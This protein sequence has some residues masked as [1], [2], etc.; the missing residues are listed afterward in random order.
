MPIIIHGS[1]AITGVKQTGI[2][3]CPSCNTK[4]DYKWKHVR[5]WGHLYFIPIAPGQVLGEYVE[6]QRCMN[7]YKPGV[8]DYDPEAAQ[9][10]FEATYQSGMK[11]VMVRMMASDGSIDP[12][13]VQVVRGIFGRL[14]G[15][16][17]SDD[18]LNAEIEAARRDPQEIGAA[19]KELAGTLNEKGKAA[20]V[21]AAYL[22]AS[23]D[24]RFERAE[25]ELLNQV[26]GGLGMSL[27]Q[28]Q[29]AIRELNAPAES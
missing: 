2:F 1:R 7:T 9:K 4:V 21:K 6:C 5:K 19:L 22:V 20:V 11:R 10:A 26:A 8:L 3:H 29:Q 24:G 17:L 27:E 25:L 12:A 23:A 16:T 14:A 15:R 13:E 18:E 28:T